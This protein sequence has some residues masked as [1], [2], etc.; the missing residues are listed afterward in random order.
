MAERRE[1]FQVTLDLAE[2]ESHAAS[3]DSTIRWASAI[4]LAQLGTEDAITL[5]WSLTDDSDENVRDAARIGL[6]QCD[7]KIVGKVLSTNW[8]V[9]PEIAPSV[10]IDGVQQHVPWKVRP[11]EV[12]S[13]E[14]DWAI[15]AAVLNIIQ[16]EAPLTGLRLMRLYGNAV[17]PDNPK[18]TP[19]SRIQQAIK[20]LERRGLVAYFQNFPEGSFVGWTIY[21][22][23]N[24]Q[25]VVR[26]RGQRKL[27]EIP[28]TEAI[29]LLRLLIGD[30]FDSSSNDERFNLLVSAYGIKQSELHIV[31]EILAQEWSTLLT[32]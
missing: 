19:K 29:A 10:S 32:L 26:D 21:K 11:L 20:R 6:N 12:S 15:D 28:V 1:F 7:Q 16:T 3:S 13:L 24:S 22:V 2:L 14:V 4:E 27:V 18:K 23:G 25:V 30:D 8:V 31:G 9:E 5:L 17:F